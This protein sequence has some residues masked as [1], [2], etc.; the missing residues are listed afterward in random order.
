MTV[1]TALRVEFIGVWLAV[2]LHYQVEQCP[3]WVARV[4]TSQV[5]PVLF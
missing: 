1:P 3:L 5:P 4:S 2:C